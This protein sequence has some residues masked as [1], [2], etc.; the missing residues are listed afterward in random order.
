MKPSLRYACTALIGL[1]FGPGLLSGQ[2]ALYPPDADKLALIIAISD[3]GTP[4]PDPNTK[5]SRMHYGNL[6]A[7]NDVPLIEGALIQQGFRPEAIRVL[8]D[9]QATRIEI[10]TALENLVIA[11]T[12]GDVVVFHYS[13]HG[14]QIADDDGPEDEIDGYDELLVPYA[15]PATFTE[16]YAG[17]LHIRDDVIGR[18]VQRLREKVGPTGNVTFFLDACYSGTGTRGS[19]ELPVR[20]ASGPLGPPRPGTMGSRGASDEDPMGTGFEVPAAPGTRGDVGASSDDGLAPFVVISAASHREVAWETYDVDNVTK[21]GSLSYALARALPKLRPG[22]SYRAL[23]AHIVSALSGKVPQTPQIEGSR[24]AVVFSGRIRAQTAYVQVDTVLNASALLIGGGSLLG[25]NAGSEIAFHPVGT[26]DPSARAALA[27]GTVAAALPLAARVTLTEGDA[28]GLK[29]SW[30]F[31]TRSSLGGLATRVAFGDSV[32]PADRAEIEEVLG[33]LG[34]VEVVTDGPEL[35]IRGG[36]SR[37][38]A[39]PVPQTQ[40]RAVGE[41][42]V[43]GPFDP[44]IRGI[45][46]HARAQYIR[47]LDLTASEI[48]VDFELAPVE[49]EYDLLGQ[50][51][52]CT[53]ANWGAVDAHPGNIGGGQWRLPSG[54]GY[55]LR[56]RNRS[57]R[58]VFIALLDIMP[59]NAVDQ[60]FPHR[61]Y[62]PDLTDVEGGQSYEIPLCFFTEEFSGAETLKLFAT[63]DPVDFGAL[64]QSSGSRGAARGEDNLSAL[65]A[66]VGASFGS[67]RAGL[68]TAPRGT[69]TTAEIVIH[70][71]GG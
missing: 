38:Q 64:L 47:R 55:R 56:M 70:I 45:T 30:A 26:T 43:G 36:A 60:L 5:Q 29:D 23:Y 66:V 44:L 17:Q 11:A 54:T 71:P 50:A 63:A 67:T 20:G 53:A 12:P 69:A 4:P 37:V 22:D 2:G 62:A 39:F 65:E 32:A 3:Y 27:T 40:P 41:A 33:A 58:T 24:D 35:L 16:G 57:E 1:C 59:D 8:R 34:V 6:N 18:F 13:G 21:V 15:A 10:L 68:V 49:I 42:R 61:D 28:T 25:I 14:H 31:V 52:G 51:V 19:S 48:Q 46:A 9:A 7:M